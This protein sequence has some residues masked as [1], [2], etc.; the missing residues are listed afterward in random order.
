MTHKGEKSLHVMY[1]RRH[2]IKSPTLF[3]MP[4]YMQVKSLLDV[5]YVMP[6][7]A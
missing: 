5:M 7:L 4:G 2:I 3:G 6:H 1:V